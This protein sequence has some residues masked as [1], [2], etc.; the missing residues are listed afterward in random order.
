MRVSFDGFDDI[1]KEVEDELKKL[2]KDVADF[3]NKQRGSQYNDVFN[4]LRKLE[5]NLEK[6]NKKIKETQ[7]EMTTF[8]DELK[9]VTTEI[10]NK[11]SIKSRLNDLA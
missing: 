3:M 8:K 10:K 2:E 4:K 6:L 5:N 11:E 7:D 1:I 9:S